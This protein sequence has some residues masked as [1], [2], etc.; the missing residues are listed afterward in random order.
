MNFV[1][2]Y[3][4]NNKNIINNF[5]L[6]ILFEK[7]YEMKL[8][9][10]DSAFNLWMYNYEV[11]TTGYKEFTSLLKKHWSDEQRESFFKFE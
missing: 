3:S 9:E 11:L 5:F 7:D 8:L 4:I 1:F 10:G 2:L 6:I